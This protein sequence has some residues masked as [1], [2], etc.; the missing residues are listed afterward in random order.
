MRGH[1]YSLRRTVEMMRRLRPVVGINE[2]W[3]RT[4]IPIG[5][6]QAHVNSKPATDDFRR[7]GTSVPSAVR[8]G[9]ILRRKLRTTCVELLLILLYSAYLFTQMTGEKTAITLIEGFWVL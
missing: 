2:P 8:A 9:G 6:P 4:F 7:S 3:E 5:R 1:N